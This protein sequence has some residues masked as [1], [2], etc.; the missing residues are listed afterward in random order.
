MFFVFVLR[1]VPAV[2]Q[3]EGTGEQGKRGE[4]RFD[5]GSSGEIGGKVGY[6]NCVTVCTGSG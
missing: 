5:K 1:F 6:Q 3:N 2:N 4:R